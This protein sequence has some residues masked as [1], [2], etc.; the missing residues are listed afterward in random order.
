M[1]QSEFQ[2]ECV[3]SVDLHVPMC[4]CVPGCLF[5]KGVWK[6][7]TLRVREPVVQ[8]IC[9]KWC[10]RMELVFRSVHSFVRLIASLRTSH[11]S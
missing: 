7:N 2:S 4:D 3:D 9:A 11:K 1:R 5:G 10:I 6:L 8:A